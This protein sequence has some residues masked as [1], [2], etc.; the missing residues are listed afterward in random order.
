MISKNLCGQ[1][2][3]RNRESRERN[4]SKK[5][6]RRNTLI[7]KPRPTPAMR[8]GLSHAGKASVTGPRLLQREP[9]S[10]H[11]FSPFPLVGRRFRPEGTPSANR[12]IWGYPSNGIAV[13]S[14]VLG[15]MWPGC[16]SLF[17]CKAHVTPDAGT[18]CHR[19]TAGL[20]GG[21]LKLGS[22]ARWV[23]TPRCRGTEGLPVGPSKGYHPAAVCSQRDK[24]VR[25][26]LDNSSLVTYPGRM[27]RR[28]NVYL[29]H[30]KLLSGD[31][32]P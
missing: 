29:F 16:K 11:S 1:Q 10:P 32:I 18:W 14:S 5:R 22:L 2:F 9:L 3:R 13:I 12:V 21:E 7:F 17:R 28:R 6:R 24:S 25:S 19:P 31:A 20:D 27:L 15:V 23:L 4:A 26:M 30:S 8:S